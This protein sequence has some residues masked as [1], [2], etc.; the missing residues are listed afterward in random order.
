MWSLFLVFV[1]SL[2]AAINSIFD[3]LHSMQHV[4]GIHTG[5]VHYL[6]TPLLIHKRMRLVSTV[7]T[8]FDIVR[9]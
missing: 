7:L 9:M 2:A 3:E 6:H 4:M 5:L 8:H 1:R